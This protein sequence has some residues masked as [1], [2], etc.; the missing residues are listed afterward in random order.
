MGWDFKQKPGLSTREKHL[1]TEKLNYELE[2]KLK[3]QESK[4]GMHL[5]F[6]IPPANKTS[7]E[8][9]SMDVSQLW[10]VCLSDSHFEIKEM[11]VCY[12]LYMTVPLLG[13]IIMK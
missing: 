6:C 2:I 1:A 9:G 3:S 12:P 11:G 4:C 5:K 10:G 13:R 8:A 7:A